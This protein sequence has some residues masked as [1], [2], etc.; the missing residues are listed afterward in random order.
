M[1]NSVY[2]FLL[3]QPMCK[4]Y[5]VLSRWH[6]ANIFP[7]SFYAFVLKRMLWTSSMYLYL[8]QYLY[9]L[10]MPNWRRNGRNAGGCFVGAGLCEWGWCAK[11]IEIHATCELVLLRQKWKW[12]EGCSCVK[13]DGISSASSISLFLSQL[14]DPCIFRYTCTF[15]YFPHFFCG[16][17]IN[18]SRCT[19][20]ATNA[21]FIWSTLLFIWWMR[22]P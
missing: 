18:V 22:V 16:Y 2:V 10:K 12:E 9:T 4:R 5:A 14:F 20:P 19:P 11:R 17:K 6:L 1:S 13:R 8:Y 15:S 21:I 7:L 3:A